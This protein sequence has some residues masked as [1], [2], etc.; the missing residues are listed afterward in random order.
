[1]IAESDIIKLNSKNSRT[2]KAV[3][4]EPTRSD[5]LWKDA[6]SLVKAL[7]GMVSKGKGSR[8]RFFLNGVVAS[9]HEPHPES[10]LSEGAVE[11]FRTFLKN[12]KPAVRIK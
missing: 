12:A 6:C 4:E 11:S 1:M 2:H 7:G 5:I 9:M 3:F 8:R 10:V